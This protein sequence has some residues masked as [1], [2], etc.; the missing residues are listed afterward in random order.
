VHAQLLYSHLLARLASR[1]AGVPMMTTW[2]NTIYDDAMLAELGG[3]PSLRDLVRAFDRASAGYE[4][5]FIA[6]S[7]HVAD[8]WTR[9]LDIA[10]ERVSI[11]HNAV[12]PDRYRAATAEELAEARASVPVEPGDEILI[13]VGR[14]VA[15]KGH[16]EALAALPEVLERR[17]RVRLLI[18]GSGPLEA[19]LR[20][21]AERLRVADRVALLGQRRDIFAL[22]RLANGFVFAT[23][24]EGLSLALVELLAL[25]LPG[26][27]SDIP[28]NREVAERLG[29][30]RFFPVGDS[31]AIASAIVS[32]LETKRPPTAAERQ[33]ISARFSPDALALQLGAELER[34]AGL[35][36]TPE[37]ERLR[38]VG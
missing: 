10:P 16:L 1:A 12:E 4:R 27:I 28:P 22:A 36:P 20:A 6:V 38:G 24:S 2:Q 30:V 8:S 19:E 34:T 25:G 7:R 9:W 33:A 21:Q 31:P 5:R 11:I 15:A 35:P 37:L 26:V 3:S 14:L 29:C 18:A 23:H 17:P 32:M 13:S